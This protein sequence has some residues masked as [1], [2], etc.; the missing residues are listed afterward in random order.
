[1]DTK[2][3]ND[4]DLG[5]TGQNFDPFAF[6]RNTACD[7]G[8]WSSAAETTQMRAACNAA[9]AANPKMKAAGLCF[10]GSKKCV[11]DEHFIVWMRTA[12]LPTFRKLF[13]RIDTTL[14]PGTYSFK[15]SNGVPY[16]TTNG[17]EAFYNPSLYSA[18]EG[19]T[20]D[21]SSVTPP[22]AAVQKFL[23]PVHPFDGTKTI[24]LSTAS[25]IGG[26]NAFLGWS[27]L[28]VGI[29]CVVLAVAF[30]VKKH[31]FPRKL[32]SA[33]YVPSDK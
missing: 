2:F 23:Y 12:G 32:G 17:T 16:N 24:V 33:P 18:P 30:A 15:V 4:E 9:V 25:W 21:P 22:D 6:E 11:E 27:Y 14:E 13:G 7:D 31:F 10:R 3:K 5:S 26:R 20:S 28:V 1:V 19:F 8:V 29:V